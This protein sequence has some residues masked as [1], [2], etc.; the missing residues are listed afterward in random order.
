M[1]LKIVKCRSTG[2]LSR[3]LFT[4]FAVRALGGSLVVILVSIVCG[5]TSGCANGDSTFSILT[6]S[7]GGG[8]YE[9]LSYPRSRPEI[10]AFPYAQLGVRLPAAPPGILVLTYLGE[11]GEE[12]WS[13]SDGVDFTM[14][15]GRIFAV[16]GTVPEFRVRVGRDPLTESLGVGL[17]PT[18]GV[19][20]DK[21]VTVVGDKQEFVVELR[22]DFELES[23]EQTIV[24]VDL[25][26]LVR[27]Y[28]EK[29]V[30]DDGRV[31]SSVYQ[32]ATDRPYVWSS[33]QQAAP[34]LPRIEVDV[35][36][37]PG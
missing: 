5:V 8:D 21:W 28:T 24:V 12:V 34:G 25:P 33:V 9:S 7:V 11:R 19:S 6:R 14:A 35:L 16:V 37:R 3:L 4:D 31:S 10:E 23:T 2:R 22:C 17:L 1:N 36:K 15:G 30:A 32:V 20:Y 26:Q 18:P 27:T 29:C 13:S